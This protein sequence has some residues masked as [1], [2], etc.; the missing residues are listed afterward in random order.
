MTVEIHPG[1]IPLGEDRFG[2]SMRFLNGRFDL[3]VSAQ[4]TD[5]ALCIFDTFRDTCGGPPLHY[6][7]LQ[8]EWFMVLEGQFVFQIGDRR[9][10]IGPGDSIFVPR[11]TPHAFRNLSAQARVLLA[12]T[13]AMRM[14][15]M[16]RSGLG[17]DAAN[18]ARFEELHREHHTFNVG[19]PLEAEEAG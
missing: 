6:H 9:H 19:P 15:D 18:S 1:M 8:G 10:R 5:G 17:P 12:F 13:P 2:A 11:R 14:E 16:F 4:D 3:K 7:E